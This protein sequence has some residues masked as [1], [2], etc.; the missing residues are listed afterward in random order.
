MNVC[1][2][3]LVK[4]TASLCMIGGDSIAL[5]L[6]RAMPECCVDAQNCITSAAIISRVHASPV[7]IISAGSNDP[8]NWRLLANLKAI[9][10]RATGQVIFIAPA[11]RIAAQAVRDAA[12]PGDAVIGFVAGG[13]GVHPKNIRALAAAVRRAMQH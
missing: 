8:H 7:M 2:I 11:D 10:G 3:T 9:R 1:A 4:L 6:A 12:A 13:D 5:D